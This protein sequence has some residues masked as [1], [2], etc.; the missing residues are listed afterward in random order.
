MKDH[1]KRTVIAGTGHYLPDRVVTSEE[2]EEKMKC[3]LDFVFPKGS[4]ENL[5]GVRQRRYVEEGFH[6]SDAAQKASEMAL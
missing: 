6:P 3:Q 2:I 5:C 4:I 1:P